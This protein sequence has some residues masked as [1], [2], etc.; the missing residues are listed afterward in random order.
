[1]ETRPLHDI[2][3]DQTLDKK[4][5]TYLKIIKIQKLKKKDYLQ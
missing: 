2:K 4:I 3:P 1:M 5:L